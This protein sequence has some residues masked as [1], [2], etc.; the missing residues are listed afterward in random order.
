M[1]LDFFTGF[2]HYATADLTT[3]IT[4]R[5]TTVQ[6]A[7]I[8]TSVFRNGSRG[9]SLDVGA[10]SYVK[11]TGLSNAATRILG[12]GFRSTNV[13]GS[14][15]RIIAALSDGDPSTAGNVN[16]GLA[17][18]SSAKLEVYNGR[19][20][21]SNSGGTKLGSSSTNT[22]SS[23]TWYFIEI[24]V[25]V[26]NSTGT[27]EVYVNGSKTN[28]I[29]LT[30]QDTQGGANAY[31]NAFG[32]GGMTTGTNTDVFDD[33]YCVSGS[34]GTVTTRL[35]D[36]KAVAVVASSGD[37]AL[38]QFTP[39]TGTD[40]GAMVDDATPN[41]DTD[42]NES[43]SVGNIDT[44]AFAAL[45]SVGTIYGLNLHNYVKKTDATGCD[46]TGVVRIGSTN[47]LGTQRALGTSYGYITDLM[48]LSP[49]TSAAWVPSEVDGAEFGVKHAA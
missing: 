7:T 49:A 48:E 4:S 39:S 5:F 20:L 11:K 13:L 23:N 29:D 28:W 12:F 2:D 36:V 45:G 27:V 3:G 40:N 25:T 26:H 44:Y 9:L 31:S 17:I 6:N 37:G 47:Y 41:G 33:L 14:A 16:I 34:G 35:G 21:N 42:Y 32:F 38:G 19:A 24:V 43:T 15:G 46:A 8:Q 30:G 10:T 18:D 1:A 22:L